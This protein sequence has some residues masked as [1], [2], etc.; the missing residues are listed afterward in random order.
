[1]KSS[2]NTQKS[3]G[4]GLV[5]GLSSIAHG[6]PSSALQGFNDLLHRAVTNGYVDYSAF[7]Q[8]NLFSAYIDEIETTNPA[9]IKDPAEK[10]TFYIN[11]YNALAIQSIA[12]GRS[13]ASLFGR[14]KFF[15]TTKV[16]VGGKSLSLYDLERDDILTLGEPRVHFALVCASAS[17]PP[18]RS[19]IYTAAELDQQLDD[20]ARLFINDASKNSF[21][22]NKRK[23]SISR[24][25]KWYPDDFESGDDD[26]GDYLARYVEDRNVAAMLR[27]GEFKFKFQKYD[28][29]LNGSAP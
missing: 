1:M 2:L 4:L 6:E 12:L 8:S 11:A 9:S 18:L 16:T 25:F 20:Q 10:L 17:C 15:K 27:A 21:D 28:W 14:L 29:S 13:P 26:L 5:L 22:A 19:E 24:I 3:L 23:A 7:A